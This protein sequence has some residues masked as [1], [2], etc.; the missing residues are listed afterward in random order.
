LT[1][2]RWWVSGVC[3]LH[4]RDVNAL[5]FATPTIVLFAVAPF[6]VTSAVFVLGVA[7]LRPGG[8]RVPA[9]RKCS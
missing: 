7:G 2:K 9:D 1:G 5:F 6:I 3:D 4:R 8:G